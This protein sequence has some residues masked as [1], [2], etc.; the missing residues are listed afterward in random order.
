MY[1]VRHARCIRHTQTLTLVSVQRRR[2]WCGEC[3]GDGGEKVSADLWE[4]KSA[5]WLVEPASNA[6]SPCLGAKP[7]RLL[8]QYIYYLLY[9]GKHE[10]RGAPRWRRRCA[11]LQG[12]RQLDF[13]P[14][15]QM[16][17]VKLKSQ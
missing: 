10:R 1:H 4:I 9:V 6:I 8:S 15:S 3:R 7:G 5:L 14:Q 2:P 11:F 12:E 13:D 17:A 16:M